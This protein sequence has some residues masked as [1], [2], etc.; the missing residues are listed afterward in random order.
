MPDCDPTYARVRL[1]NG[2]Q[3]FVFLRNLTP[4]ARE[5]STIVRDPSSKLESHSLPSNSDPSISNVD[6]TNVSY[7]S[8][9]VSE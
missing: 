3:D 9:V 4:A 2:S 8:N 1:P 7:Y 6:L 5:E